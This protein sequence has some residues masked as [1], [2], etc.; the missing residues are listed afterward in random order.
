M[1]PDLVRLFEGSRVPRYTSYP[2]A[3]QFNTEVG[4]ADHAEWLRATSAIEPASIYVHMPFCRQLCWYCACTTHVAGDQARV[5]AYSE[6]LAR[7][8]ALVRSMLPGRLPVS[9]LHWG[10]GTPTIAGAKSFSWLMS[11]IRELFD[12]EQDAEIAVELDPRFLEQRMIEALAQTGINRASIGIQ[13]FDPVVQAAIN[14]EQSFDLTRNAVERLG[15][16]GIDKINADLLY[17]LPYQTV[18]NCL[19]TIDQVLRLEPHRLAVFGYAHLPRLKR[20]QTLIDEAVLPNAEERLRQ[21]QAITAALTAAG[22]VQIGLDHFARPE[23]PMALAVADGTLRRN[24]QGYTT[25]KA[26]TLLGFGASSISSFAQGYAQNESD[27]RL[28]RQK[29]RD[30]VLPTARGIRLKAS[31]IVERS[32][33]EEIMCQGEVDLDRVAKTHGVERQQCEPNVAQLADLERSGIIERRGPRIRVKPENRALLRIVAAAFD[34]YF[35]GNA[36]RHAVAV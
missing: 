15:K 33:I 12:V 14:R 24:F 10:G 25:D 7:E 3:T 29:I 17:G 32:I 22:Y 11:V 36:E 28:Y 13:S 16:V 27:L 9:H 35:S 8:M 5:D 19:A 2:T 30:G 4:S 26:Q 21:Y 6:T 23:D 18:E 1:S 20:H 34:R 31:D